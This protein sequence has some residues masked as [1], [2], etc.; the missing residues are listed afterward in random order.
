MAISVS[1]WGNPG[2]P[3]LV[4]HGDQTVSLVVRVQCDGLPVPRA[5]DPVCLQEVIQAGDERPRG[6]AQV[7]GVEGGHDFRNDR[8]SADDLVKLGP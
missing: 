3:V 2:I 6:L 7:H 1:V 5:A 4:N 8:K